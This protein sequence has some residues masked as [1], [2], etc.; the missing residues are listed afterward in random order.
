[1]LAYSKQ[2]RNFKRAPHLFGIPAFI[3]LSSTLPVT[4]LLFAKPLEN[5]AIEVR[6]DV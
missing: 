4:H 1:M 3:L 5:G 2:E 6:T